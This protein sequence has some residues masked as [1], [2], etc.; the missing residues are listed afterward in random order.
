MKTIAGLVQGSDQWLAHR[1]TT[2]NASD[3]SVMMGS[4][5]SISRRELVRLMANGLEREFSD[6]VQK[7][8]LDRGHEVEPAL[9]RFAE[10]LIEDELYPVTATTDDGY[11]GAS[12]DGITL[13]D[14]VIFEA[15]QASEEKFQCI[16]RGEIPP[17]DKWQIT[18]QF[19]VCESAEVC[20]YCVG[21]GTPDGTRFLKIERSQ[22]EA[23][24]PR[25]IAAWRQFDEDV[26]NYAPEPEAAP[27]PVGRAP[28]QLPA[29]SVQ[30]TGM[31][32]ASNLA[33][34]K[35]NAMAVLGSINRELTTDEDFANAEKTVKWCSGVEERLKATKDQI[36]GQT[37]D[38]DAVFR[39]M[40][41]VSAETRR[42]RLELSKL[43]EREKENRKT[44]IVTRGRTAYDQHVAGLKAETKDVWLPLSAPDF[45]GAIK[46]KKS[47]S[48]MQD[49][50]DTVLAHAKIAA[51]ESAKHIRAAL[52]LLSEETAEHKH[53][54]P[55]YLTFIGKPLEDIRALV[56]GR[57]AEHKAA[58]EK[59]AEELRERIR[60]EEQEKLA[61]EQRQ[62]EAEA[63][64][65]EPEPVPTPVQAAPVAA[66]QTQTPAVA[67]APASTARIKLGDINARIAP[68]SISADGLASLGFQPVGKE[69]AAKL[70]AEA[71]M[72]R[73]CAALAQVIE[74]AKFTSTQRAA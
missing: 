69:G 29:L 24:I 66:A 26:A 47:L 38:I 25:L 21:D 42:I 14:T 51:N 73:I 62:R 12:F 53:L 31:V 39:T 54:F 55:D 16:E 71:D 56:R 35:A 32:T 20:Y 64:K 17:A 46:G 33:E 60:K 59:K 30:V 11:M 50:V 67:A 65:P 15:K 57:I 44:E 40:D 5:P 4:S 7:F 18:Q 1:R 22:I 68:L 37:A 72:G 6:Y 9:R 63:I 36:L 19:A 23:D 58:E 13:D 49:A 8:I 70:Y 52:A 2:R 61:D 74:R 45:A 48:S 34:F 3:A 10:D 43:V 27:I 28:E 41:E